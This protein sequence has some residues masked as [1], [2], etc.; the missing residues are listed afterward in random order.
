MENGSPSDITT[1]GSVGLVTD[2]QTDEVFIYNVTGTLLGCWHFD[3][4]NADPSGITLDPSG[5]NDLWVVDRGDLLVYH[6]AAVAAL[7]SGNPTASGTFPLV[8]ENVQPEGIADPPTDGV[9]LTIT[10]IDTSELVYDGQS[11]SVSGEISATISNVGSA[12]VLQAFDVVIFEDLDLDG[13][14]DMSV[15]NVLGTIAITGPLAAG[16]SVPGSTARG[17]WWSLW[18]TSSGALWTAATSWPRPTRTITMVV[19]AASFFPNLAYSILRLNGI[20]VPSIPPA[21]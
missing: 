18:T 9:D 14:Y 3:P 10:D 13:V 16:E 19:P 5:G 7:A 1:N 6:Y 21:I 11:L 15:D 4:A 17:E 2:D 20:R 12:D 8:S